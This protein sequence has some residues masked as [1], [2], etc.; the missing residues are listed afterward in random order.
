MR[1]LQDPALRI[2]R[3]STELLDVVREVLEAVD[4]VRS[5]CELLWVRTPGKRLRR[6]SLENPLIYGAGDRTDLLV[7]AMPSPG[8][9][10]NITASA[11]VK[12]VI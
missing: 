12:L 11:S 7:E 2:I 8:D 4:R 10:P 6:P 1:L 5:H 9:D 3:T